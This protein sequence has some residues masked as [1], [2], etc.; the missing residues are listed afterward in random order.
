MARTGEPWAR[1][2]SLPDQQAGGT[3]N[4]YLSLRPATWG[5]DVPGD[6]H[7]PFG[8]G[9]GS[10]LRPSVPRAPASF[11]RH[12]L[13]QVPQLIHVASAPPCP[14]A[15]SIPEYSTASS[16]KA[17]ARRTGTVASRPPNDRQLFTNE[18][19]RPILHLAGLRGSHQD[20]SR[21][22]A[23]QTKESPRSRES[24]GRR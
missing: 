7:Q 20:Q 13:S 4:R 21:C 22:V 19:I 3:G 1:T 2:L 18:R 15:P 17:L 8:P 5:N 14:L 10:G 12:A 16:H 23:S 9:G 6:I 11:H 24:G